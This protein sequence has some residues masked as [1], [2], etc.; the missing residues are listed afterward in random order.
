VLQLRLSSRLAIAGLLT[1]PVEDGVG[2]ALRPGVVHGDEIDAI[3]IHPGE[4][5]QS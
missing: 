4:D 5:Q 2:S 1:N 3:F